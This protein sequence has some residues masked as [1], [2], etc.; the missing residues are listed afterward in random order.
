MK[1]KR[2]RDPFQLAKAIGD[3]AT[4]HTD[5]PDPLA[6]KNAAAV[7]LGRKGGAIGGKR[8]A[9]R[10]TPQ[11]RKENARRAA[12]ARWKSRDDAKH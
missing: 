11:Q 6:G 9:E 3:I 2:P 8:T 5:D 4:G 12:I 7:E 10:L 1:P